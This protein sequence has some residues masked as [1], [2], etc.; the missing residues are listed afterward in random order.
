MTK[1]KI[2]FT[3]TKVE[4]SSNPEIP[5]NVKELQLEIAS[6]DISTYLNSIY[7]KFPL[8]TSLEKISIIFIDGAEKEIY[9]NLLDKHKI[10]FE[11]SWEKEKVN[12]KLPGIEEPEEDNTK[13]DIVF[14][15]SENSLQIAFEPNFTGVVKITSDFQEPSLPEQITDLKNQ[16]RALEEK[17]R[18]PSNPDTINEQ[19]KQQIQALKSQLEKKEKEEKTQTEKNGF[20][21]EWIIGAG[22]AFVIVLLI[23]ILLSQKNQNKRR[24][25]N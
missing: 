24:W 22:I 9:D 1:I 21:T 3:K 10:S 15:A 5:T 7:D 23:A 2:P 25:I 19:Y 14:F 4:K 11:L 20:P 16:I 12:F 13:Q 17:M 6:S 8:L 18:N